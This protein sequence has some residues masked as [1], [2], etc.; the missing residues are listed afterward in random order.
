M[1]INNFASIDAQCFQVPNPGGIRRVLVLC[2]RFIA[3][4]WPT[5]AA[6]NADNEVTAAPTYVEPLTTKWAEYMFPDGTASVAS[7]GGGDP[8]YESFKH[9]VEIAM[10]GF[11]KEV[12]KE[13]R[14]HLNAGSVWIFELK[15]GKYVVAGSSDDPIFV[16]PSFNSG[17]KGNDKR[18][19]TMKGEVDGI[20][21]DLPVLTS[22]LVTGLP[23]APLPVVA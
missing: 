2:S 1:P 19:Y 23:I 13:I 7:D 22:A 4:P 8:G 5:P 11:S 3:A 17:K 12:R 10:A 15:D 9:M 16:K 14:K 18:G 6:L 21:W 20:T